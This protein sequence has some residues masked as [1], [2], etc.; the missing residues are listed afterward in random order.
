MGRW[1]NMATIW[2]MRAWLSQWLSEGAWDS[3]KDRYHLLRAMHEGG[4][5]QERQQFP[6]AEQL[7]A[8][9]AQPAIA[10]RMHR[11]Q[12]Q[13]RRGVSKATTAAAAPMAKTEDE[14][15]AVQSFAQIMEQKRRQ[16]ES[17]AAAAVASL[18]PR[19]EDVAREHAQIDKEEQELLKR[20]AMHIQTMTHFQTFELGIQGYSNKAIERAAKQIAAQGWSVHIFTNTMMIQPGAVLSTARV[21]ASNPPAQ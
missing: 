19:M 4:F 13:H 3:S 2:S 16:L 20:V 18:V 6:T 21:S 1:Y 9:C 7:D 11:Y 5:D 12:L 15:F 8:F 17:A 10:E 14:P